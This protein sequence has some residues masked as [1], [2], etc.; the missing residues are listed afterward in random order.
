MVSFEKLHQ[1]FHKNKIRCG[2]FSRLEKS[3]LVLNECTK[4]SPRFYTVGFADH[5]C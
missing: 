2:M 1:M 3:K 4:I 5:Q